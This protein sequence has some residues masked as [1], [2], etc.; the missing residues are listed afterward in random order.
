MYGDYPASGKKEYS[1]M[2]LSDVRQPNEKEYHSP[3]TYFGGPTRNW[4]KGDRK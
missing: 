1:C 3:N 2:G 4:E